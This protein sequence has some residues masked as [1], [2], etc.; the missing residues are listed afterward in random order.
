MCYRK[1]VPGVK[2]HLLRTSMTLPVKR[3]EVFSFFA[4]AS[5]LERITP[6]ELCFQILTPEPVPITE[7]TLILYR[8][9]LFGIPFGWKTMITVWDPPHQFVD[10]QISGPYK[11]WVHTHRF[12]E[13]KASTVIIDT[14]EYQLPLWPVGEIAYPFVY[15]QLKR[16]FSYRQQ[17]VRKILLALH[18]G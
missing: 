16:I 13:D 10:Q 18:K 6:P 11:L 9:R 3:E 14:V 1:K 8:L 2:T 7:S 5:N 4:N 17:M 15:F 12:E